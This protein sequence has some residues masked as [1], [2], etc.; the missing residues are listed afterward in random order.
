MKYIIHAYN[1]KRS[2]KHRTA[3]PRF[4]H[5]ELDLIDCIEIL[6]QNIFGTRLHPYWGNNY[7]GTRF[8]PFDETIGITPPVDPNQY[9]DVTDATLALLEVNERPTGRLLYLAKCMKQVVPYSYISTKM[10]VKLYFNNIRKFME[11][12]QT[13]C[14]EKMAESWNKGLLTLQVDEE[15]VKVPPSNANNVRKKLPVHLRSYFSTYLKLFR[16]KELLRSE[17]ANIASVYLSLQISAE[18]YQF[19]LDC[20]FVEDDKIQEASKVAPPLKLQSYNVKI[21]KCPDCGDQHKSAS[22][23]S[24]TQH[25]EDAHKISLKRPFAVVSNVSDGVC[26]FTDDDA[27]RKPDSIKRRPRTCASCHRTDCKGKDKYMAVF[28]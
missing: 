25:L 3:F 8:P 12:R 15:T 26:L 4:G 16:R 21:C 17:N 6:Y 13:P 19:C 22:P 9:E 5:T 18:C 11:N 7:L 23:K 27:F 20:E 10:E 14:F 24:D 1:I 2:E 28:I